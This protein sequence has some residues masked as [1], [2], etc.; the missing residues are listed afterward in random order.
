MK[1]R[2]FCTRLSAKILLSVF[3]LTLAV[4]AAVP[5]V[6]A[7]AGTTY[8]LNEYFQEPEDGEDYFGDVTK[9]VKQ[10]GASVRGLVMAIGIVFLVISI[11]IVGLTMA[12]K[13]PNEREMAKSRLVAIIIG[14]IIFFSGLA[15][16]SLA[17]RIANTVGNAIPTPT[18]GVII[19]Y[20]YSI[21]RAL[22]FFF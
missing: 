20:Q 19:T 13:N 22:P 4:T 9:V 12:K 18:P 3:V 17:Q 16:L 10:G 1:L 5:A 21:I 11:S 6:R 2:N 7:K 8:D 14:A 15:I